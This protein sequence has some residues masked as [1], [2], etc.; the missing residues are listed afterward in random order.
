MKRKTYRLCI[1]S[2]CEIWATR[3]SSSMTPEEAAA[4]MA[5][6]SSDYVLLPDKSKGDGQKGVVCNGIYYQSIRS[7]FRAWRRENT[8]PKE[9]GRKAA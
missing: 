4:T 3:Y 1:L 8:E 2:G 9:T 6:I 7:Y 5:T